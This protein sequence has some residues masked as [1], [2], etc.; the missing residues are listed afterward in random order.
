VKETK[1]IIA[2]T[3]VKNKVD[4]QIRQELLKWYETITHHIYFSSERKILIQQD[5]LAMGV[6]F[7]GLIAEF[8]L[9]NLEDSQLTQP[10]GKVKITAYFR[11][12]DD[13]LIIYDSRHTDIKNIQDDFNMLHPNLK[14]TAEP[15]RVDL[16]VLKVWF[17]KWLSSRMEELNVQERQ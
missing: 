6:P 11:Y 1:D 7:S 9:Q 12:I 10:F 17:V 4:P 16:S 13:I 15:G 2:N 14:F 5:G 3:L 8:F